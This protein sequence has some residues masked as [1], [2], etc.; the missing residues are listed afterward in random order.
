VTL[1][2]FPVFLRKPELCAHTQQ[3]LWGHLCWMPAHIIVRP[4]LFLLSLC[5]SAQVDSLESLHGL[6]ILWAISCQNLDK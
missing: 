1:W 5:H 3:P 6:L 2:G 4:C